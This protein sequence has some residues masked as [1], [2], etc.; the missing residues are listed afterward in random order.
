M[1][2]VVGK[3]KDKFRSTDEFQKAFSKKEKHWQKENAKFGYEK[4]SVKYDRSVNESV[5]RKSLNGKTSGNGTREEIVDM[6]M[7]RLREENERIKAELAKIKKKKQILKLVTAPKLGKEYVVAKRLSHPEE[8]RSATELSMMKREKERASDH[9]VREIIRDDDITKTVQHTK[10]K[11]RQQLE[12]NEKRRVQSTKKKPV[13][14][15]PFKKEKYRGLKDKL[16]MKYYGYVTFCPSCTLLLS[17]GLPTSH[18]SEHG[19]Y[20]TPVDP[21]KKFPKKF[22]KYL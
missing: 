14:L 18:C 2:P 8:R 12:E 11:M 7:D 17:R 13:D 6:E 4:K 3:D 9:A 5:G 22:E 1:R 19:T 10:L 15:S 20:T 16:Q 21:K